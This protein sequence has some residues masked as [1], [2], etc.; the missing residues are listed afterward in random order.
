MNADLAQIEPGFSDPTLA[1][2]AVFRR[3]LE[4]LAHPGTIIDIQ[5]DAEVP[6][7]LDAATNAALLSLLDQDIGLWLSPQLGSSAASAFLRFHTGCT[8]VREAAAADFAVLGA[9]A[10]AAMLAEFSRGTED[11][12]DRSAT[13]LV[14][15]GELRDDTGWTLSG[16]GI[17]GQRSLSA[18]GLGTAFLAQWAENRAIF[19]R[20]IDIYLTCGSR[21][22]GLPRT[23]R[24]EG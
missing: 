8:L 14:Q 17:P 18:A 12:P 5:A 4:A 6:A 1:S 24:I 20:G 7:G 22:V 21:L 2:Q 16:P 23:T 13:L 11:Y 3:C 19:P 10:A 9:E 15:T